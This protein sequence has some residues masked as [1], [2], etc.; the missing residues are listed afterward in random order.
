MKEPNWEDFKN[1]IKSNE[2]VTKTDL[3][4]VLHYCGQ[5]SPSSALKCEFYLVRCTSQG[6]REDALVELMADKIIVYVLKKKEYEG[7]LKSVDDMR[8]LWLTAKETFTKVNKTGE[9]GEL[10]LFMML[11]ADGIV[12]IFSKMDLKTN[13]NMHFHGYDAIHI[14]AG[15]LVAFHFGHAKVYANFS[16]ALNNALNDIKSFNENKSQKRR[17]LRLISNNIDAGKFKGYETLIRNLINPYYPNREK[18]KEVN[19]ILICSEWEFVKD[20]SKIGTVGFDPYMKAQYEKHH[21]E[22]L[23][24]IREQIIRTDG[25]SQGTYQFYLLPIENV[26]SFRDKFLEELDR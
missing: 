1:T 5:K 12:Q 9:V 4:H 15:Q 10:L 24:E 18:Y 13:P 2:V 23:T 20:K 6:F 19:S 17:E 25:L 14:K 16:N 7:K 22:I 21:E 11:E 8:R 26:Q 3:G